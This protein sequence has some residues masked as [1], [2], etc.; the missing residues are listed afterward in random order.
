MFRDHRLFL[1]EYLRHFHDT[2]AILPSS[3]SLAK[4]LSRHVAEPASSSANGE[5]RVLEV[6]PGTGSVTRQIVT[7][8]RPS[9][10]L[11]LVELNPAFVERLEHRFQAEA[12]FAAVAERVKIM[13]CPVQALSCEQPYHAIVSG[14]PL[15]NFSVSDVECILDTMMR[16]LAPGGTLSFFEYIAIRHARAI[17]SGPAERDRLR[18]VGGV[19]DNLLEGR[20]FRRDWVWSNV[21]PAWV[22]HVRAE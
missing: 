19:L 1:R 8:L 16:L 10:R 4:A 7:R 9:D 2:G 5:R 6:G 15:N 18:G 13:N 11:E 17:V 3:R 21:P 22:H 20:E 12:P 14:L